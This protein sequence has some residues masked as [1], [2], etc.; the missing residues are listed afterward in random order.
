MATKVVALDREGRLAWGLDV[1]EIARVAPRIGKPV[2]RHLRLEGNDYGRL[3][4]SM[5]LSVS[6]SLRAMPSMREQI[7]EQQSRKGPLN[8]IEPSRS[9]AVTG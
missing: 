3:A 1:I 8:C 6:T 7:S 4:A 5:M 2:V 9:P